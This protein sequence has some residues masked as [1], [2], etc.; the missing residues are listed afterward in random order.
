MLDAIAPGVESSSPSANQADAQ[1]S[2]EAYKPGDGPIGP[3]LGF[4]VQ[5]V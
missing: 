5:V 1:A 2:E 4:F 3:P